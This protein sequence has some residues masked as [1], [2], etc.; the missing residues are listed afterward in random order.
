[1]A[2][3]RNLITLPLL[4]LQWTLCGSK[5]V[6]V[7]LKM[8][9]NLTLPLEFTNL[10]TENTH[11]HTSFLL[12]T[13]KMQLLS[14]KGLSHSAGG[15]FNR[16]F[17]ISDTHTAGM[18]DF[19][20]T[21]PWTLHNI[22]V[23]RSTHWSTPIKQISLRTV[24]CDQTSSDTCRRCQVE[25]AS[26]SSSSQHLQ[27]LHLQ[28][29]MQGAASKRKGEAT[30]RSTPKPAK[31]PTT[32]PKQIIRF[33]FSTCPVSVLNL[34]WGGGGGREG[35][36]CEKYVHILFFRFYVSIFVALVQHALSL[37]YCAT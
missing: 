10:F 29:S 26:L 31:I 35:V 8:S 37:R 30:R 15:S 18:S 22:T 3:I 17:F 12:K 20:S 23:C 19:Q 1:M 7:N 16:H 5:K 34:V 36:V 2:I 32:C 28:H 21:L 6:R 14:A 9:N 4:L 25:M 24:T 27:I 11:K 33:N 13:N